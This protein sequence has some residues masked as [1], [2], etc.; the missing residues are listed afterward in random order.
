VKPAVI[1]PNLV[2]FDKALLKRKLYRST[3]IA[4]ITVVARFTTFC[5]HVEIDLSLQTP[6]ELGIKGVAQTVPGKIDGQHSHSHEEAREENNP[7]G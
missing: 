6:A 7:K 2:P 1:S 4:G 3:C 5:H